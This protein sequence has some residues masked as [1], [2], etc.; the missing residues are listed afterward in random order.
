[1]GVEKMEDHPDASF[2][3]KKGTTTTTVKQME[4]FSNKFFA[5]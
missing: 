1:M 4:I 2:M 5:T 3:K